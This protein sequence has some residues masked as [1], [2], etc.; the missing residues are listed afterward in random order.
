MT[1]IENKMVGWIQRH[2][3]IIAFVVA[4]VASVMIRIQLMPYRGADALIFL[5]PWS[6]EMGQRGFS[7]LATGVGN[8]NVLAQLLLYVCTLL[9]IDTI[10]GVKIF[11]MVFDYLLALGMALVV[12]T[13]RQDK[14][15]KERRNAALLTYAVAVLLPLPILNSAYWAQNE[16]IYATFVLLAVWCLLKQKYIPAFLWFGVAISIKLQ[17][18]F[19]LPLFVMLYFL[20]RKFSALCFLIPPAMLFCSAIPAVA[21]G[22]SPWYSFS[23]YALQT[24]NDKA[25]W[26]NYPGLQLLSGA[27]DY[28]NLG[29]VAVGATVLVLFF[30]LVWL[31]YRHAQVQGEGLLLL[32]AWVCMVCVM[33]LPGMHDRYGFLAETLLWVWAL[34]Y[35]QKK[36]FIYAALLTFAGYC[37]YA[38]FLFAVWPMP[39]EWVALLNV[40]VFLAFTW[41]VA[42]TLG[43]GAAGQK[44]KEQ[45]APNQFIEEELSLHGCAEGKGAATDS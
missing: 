17:A 24:D 10:D 31:L 4:I 26:M 19:I 25:I 44:E 30:M 35:P 14:P 20:H 23:V 18:I 27:W 6:Q 32:A 45:A 29:A 2:I 15:K 40:G 5:I 42:K 38:S 9:P 7:F 3:G 12:Y 41:H 33:M 21:A 11:S 43:T 1:T 34:A 39:M 28:E 16:A 8:H 37:G 22:N 36:K 13:L